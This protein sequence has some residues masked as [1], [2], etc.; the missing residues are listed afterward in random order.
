MEKPENTALPPAPSPA[1]DRAE[2]GVRFN[3]RL[4]YICRLVA[5]AIGIV[6][7]ATAALGR[8]DGTMAFIGIA[9]AVA[10][11]ALAGL[12]EH[13]DEQQRR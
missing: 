12:Q 8:L 6:V 5:L 7:A 13:Q 1:D 10:L 4:S 9:V 11:L 2:F 3:G